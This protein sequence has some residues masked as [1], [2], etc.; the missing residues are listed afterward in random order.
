MKKKVGL[1]YKKNGS[2]NNAVLTMDKN[3]I[4]ALGISKEENKVIFSIE[5]G[6]IILTKGEAQEEKES[7]DIYG[8]IVEY[9]K[10]IGVNFSKVYKDKNYYVAKLN[11][12]F[13]I[14]NILKI[15]KENNEVNITIEKD[16]VIIDREKRL[17]KVYTL[18][19]NKGGIGKTFLTVQIAHGLA[20]KGS[21][22]MILTSDSQNNIIDFTI[23][24]EKQE[25]LEMKKGLRGWVMTG[26]G[27]KIRLRKNLDFI[28]LESSVFT[29]RFL[30]KLPIFIEHL[31]REY[32]YILID[33]IPTMKIDTE[34]VKCSDK[35]IIPAFC[36]IPTLKG[37]IN[38]IEE[39]GVD[40]IHAILVNLYRTT[41]TQKNI[42]E[43]LKNI[44]EETD[45][46]FPEPIKEIALIESLVKKGKT[47]WESKAKS[48]Y[49]TQESL[50]DI[51]ME[52]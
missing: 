8:D 3:I 7:K 49:D 40:R 34:F 4:D 44:I 13:G 15:T 1:F 42:L 51:V 31:K 2:F 16:R 14:V 23:P 36:D 43:K 24:E 26:K 37:I 35:I 28:P 32:D 11:I 9:R 48:I 30:E 19:V 20:M 29:E 22:V 10:T 33:S 46:I 18:K 12:P 27:D 6:I 52:M 45:I 25:S 47:V 41:M 17:G 50:L 38:V 39:A 21:R 5:N